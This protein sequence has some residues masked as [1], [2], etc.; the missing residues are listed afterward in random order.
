M[1]AHDR[2][3]GPGRAA[4]ATG[5]EPSTSESESAHENAGEIAIPIGSPVGADELRE[6]KRRA[7]HPDPPV[8]PDTAAE[9]PEASDT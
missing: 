8:D 4:E 3:A 2:A 1:S 5:V 9:D 6:L 7:G